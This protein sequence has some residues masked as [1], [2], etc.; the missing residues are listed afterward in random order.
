MSKQL[1]YHFYLCVLSLISIS[2]C[3]QNRSN[4]TPIG[5]YCGKATEPYENPISNDNI[6]TEIFAV[7][8]NPPALKYRA[9]VLSILFKKSDSD[10]QVM[11]TH[12][13]VYFLDAVSLNAFTKSCARAI[14]LDSTGNFEAILPVEITI[15]ED[16]SWN[17]SQSLNYKIEYGKDLLDKGFL[18]GAVEDVSTP[19]PAEDI[20]FGF[21][22]A[23]FLNQIGK[24]NK[25]QKS[26][27]AKP[28]TAMDEIFMQIKVSD[29]PEIYAR[30]SF[31]KVATPVEPT[32]IPVE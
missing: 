1:I 18:N 30:I 15:N 31:K 5:T 11:Y 24:L 32:A 19:A 7:L 21:T 20:D 26:M 27:K 14:T 23:I 8:E 13:P 2:G 25:T 17:A 6:D 4:I 12:K 16:A 10:E 29:S 3:T 28:E 22:D 9:E